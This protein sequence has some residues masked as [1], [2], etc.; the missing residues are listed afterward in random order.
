MANS[1]WGEIY[2][3]GIP[4]VDDEHST[5]MALIDQLQE[6]LYAGASEQ[7]IG[8]TYSKLVS[9]TEAH[10][11]HEEQN[12]VGTAYPRA[13]I[14]ARQHKHLKTI[15]AAFQR[16]IDRTGQHVPFERQ[17]SFLRDWLTDHILNEDKPA[18]GYWKA[19]DQSNG[20]PARQP[21]T[22]RQNA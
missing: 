1:H 2:K 22:D 16:G 11:L 8:Q 4:F 15:L 21:S 9:F 7:Q 13:A 17:V 6:H 18:A 10:F 12:F 3:V 14:H 19:Q 20:A 5:L